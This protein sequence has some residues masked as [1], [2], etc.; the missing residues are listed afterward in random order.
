MRLSAM[1]ESFQSRITDPKYQGLSFE[2]R[3]D[4]C[5]RYLKSNPMMYSNCDDSRLKKEGYRKAVIKN[6]ILLPVDEEYV[7][8]IIKI[9]FCEN[10]SS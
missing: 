1:T 6:Y 9:L 4:M 3:V 8:K 2:E 7:Q 10:V 5:Y